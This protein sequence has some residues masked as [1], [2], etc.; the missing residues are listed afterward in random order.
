MIELAYSTY[1]PEPWRY[2]MGGALVL[3]S[4]VRVSSL[5]QYSSRDKIRSLALAKF[6]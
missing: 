6:S 2:R 3:K 4:S 5:M 1:S